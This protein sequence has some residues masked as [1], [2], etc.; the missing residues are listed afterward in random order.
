MAPVHTLKDL[1]EKAVFQEDFRRQ[2]PTSEK[3]TEEGVRGDNCQP[4]LS[5]TEP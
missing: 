5:M 2:E 4:C 1:I 3:E